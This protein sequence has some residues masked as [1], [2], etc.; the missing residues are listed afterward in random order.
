MLLV[1]LRFTCDAVVDYVE[2]TLCLKQDI[3]CSF[4]DRIRFSPFSGRC[5]V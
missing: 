1:E 3:V 4:N 2:G 5:L